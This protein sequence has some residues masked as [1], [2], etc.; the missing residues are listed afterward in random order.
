MLS[1][2]VASAA[3]AAA[4]TRSFVIQ[5][6]KLVR[7]GTPMQLMSGSFHYSRVPHEYWKDRL[8]RLAAMV[9]IKNP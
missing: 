9:N 6:D 1:L 3:A 7:D 2:I 8:Q 4:P 5:N